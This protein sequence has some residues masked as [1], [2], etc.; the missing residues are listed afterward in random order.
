MGTVFACR[1]TGIFLVAAS[2]PALV[3]DCG[4]HRWIGAG[5]MA[6]AICVG[7]DLWVSSWKR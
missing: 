6:L 1:L 7:I 5:L 3:A 4:K 2:V